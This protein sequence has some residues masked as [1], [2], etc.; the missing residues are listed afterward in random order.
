MENGIYV[1]LDEKMDQLLD[2]FQQYQLSIYDVTPILDKDQ[3]EKEI[4]TWMIG[5]N[6]E[7]FIILAAE[8]Y[9]LK[10]FLHKEL[11]Q[12][13]FTADYERDPYMELSTGLCKR[14]VS[15]AIQKLNPKKQKVMSRAFKHHHKSIYT[16]D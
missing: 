14:H 6:V 4:Q 3:R 9:D 10:S 11:I 13:S 1:A 5:K 16:Y 7:N 8:S 15:E 2:I 12:T